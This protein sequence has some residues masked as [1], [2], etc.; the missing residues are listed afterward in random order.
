M[1]KKCNVFLLLIMTFFGPI[2]AFWAHGLTNV[3][4]QPHFEA[5]HVKMKL[6]LPKVETW[7]PSRLP[8]LQS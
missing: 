1:K 2:V 8:K 4:S 7:S 6:A 3:L 5:S